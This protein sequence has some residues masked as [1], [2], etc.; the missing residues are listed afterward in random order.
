[1]DSLLK[2]SDSD[3]FRIFALGYSAFFD[4]A[5]TDDCN[6]DTYNYW[7]DFLPQYLDV[8]VRRKV[9]DVCKQL[10]EKIG[11]IIN[12][13]KDDKVIW[14]NW[15]P[16][17]D[18]HRFCQ[19]KKHAEDGD[20][21]W[22]FAADFDSVNIEGIN[23]KTCER[24]TEAS[25]DWGQRAACG[26]AIT[27]EMYPDAKPRV[28]TIDAKSSNPLGP[29]TARVFHPKPQGYAA[30]VEEIRSVWPYKKSDTPPPKPDTHC[31]DSDSKSS[32][33]VEVLKR[34]ITEFCRLD[35]SINQE[36]MYTD[37]G[38]KYTLRYK[39]P[40]HGWCNEINCN[41]T[42]KEAMN[43]CQD[44]SHN[45]SKNGDSSIPC[46]KFS[47]NIEPAEAP[48]SHPPPPPPCKESSRWTDSNVC[49]E[50]CPA[51][52][53]CECILAGYMIKTTSCACVCPD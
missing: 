11:E 22:F 3:S 16:R 51:P 48:E 17:F 28:G 49:K 18:K 14:V 9:N 8:D 33:S 35:F 15:A 2:K 13:R 26:I 50:H 38:V 53:K 41:S 4:D 23:T 29:G 20:N 37:D 1:M 34:H 12:D 19:P 43:T 52:G 21:T 36:R 7:W 31:Q 46:G 47:W 45:I 25:G 40:G 30:I 44:N 6:Y 5:L 27:R 10:N 42:F 24:E 39:N 32:G